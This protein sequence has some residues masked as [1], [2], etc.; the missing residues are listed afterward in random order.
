MKGHKSPAIEQIPA[1]LIREGGR[2]IRSDIY[3]IISSIWNMKEL[4]EEW[5][6]SIIVTDL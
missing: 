1:E 4:P 2:N 5:K 6:E 3:E